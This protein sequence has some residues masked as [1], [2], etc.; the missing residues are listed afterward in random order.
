MLG[1]KECEDLM[2]CDIH[3]HQEVKIEGVWH[4][5]GHPN[6]HRSYELFGI[7]AGVRGDET[8]VAHPRGIPED[9]TTLTKFSYAQWDCD[10]HH[11]SH[12]DSLEVTEVIKRFFQKSIWDQ[13][14]WFG[15]LFGG[16]WS[17]FHE[18]P[19]DGEVEDFRF[20][21]WFDN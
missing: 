12:L 17:G 11:P 16:S 15:F 4:H 9:A 19:E 7:M 3:L 21:F 14:D 20:I 2:G 10:A 18:Y 6:V 5:Y 1:T 13:T 8:P